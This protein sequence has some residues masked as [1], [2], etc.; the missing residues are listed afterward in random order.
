M[1]IM[2]K[3]LIVD[4]EKI[5]RNGIRFLLKQMGIKAEIFEAANGVKA[6]ELLE[7]QEVDLLLTD[8]KMPFMDGMTL[9]QNAAQ[10]YKDIK[11]IIFSGYGEF[12]YVKQAM[13]YSVNNYILKPVDP[14]E[15]ESTMKKVLKEIEEE[16]A[17]RELHEEGIQFVREHILLSLINGAELKDVLGKLEKIVSVDFLEQYHCM[18]LLEFDREFFGRRDEEFEKRILEDSEVMYLNLN[19]Q[20]CILL[21]EHNIESDWRDF[22]R[23]LQ[24]EIEQIY[25]ET[26][27]I[28]VSGYS[29]DALDLAASYETLETLMENKFYEPESRVFL[30]DDEKHEEEDADIEDDILV[31]QIRQDIKVKDMVG[32]REHVGLLCDKYR[33]RKALSQ[34]YVKFV[35]SNL[36]KDMY[37]V[38][39]GKDRAGFNMVVD[40]LYRANDFSEV[41][42]IL[43]DG[44]RKLEE[45][46]AVNPQ[47]MHREIETVKEYIYANYD[48]ELS[49]DMLAEQVYLA[50]SYLSHIFKK[51][52][53]QNLSKFIKSLR[54]EKAKEMLMESHLKIINISYAVGYP[55]VSYFCQSFREYFG[56][57]PQKFRNQGEGNEIH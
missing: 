20:Q 43:Q 25:H 39:P 38:L 49:V 33:G 40:R 45:V 32:L 52:T 57:S 56:V 5:E 17:E 30:A 2:I 19:Q 12:E 54:M 1:R 37:D 13:M 9:I 41:M 27:Y 16:K 31:R 21:F 28:A 7:Q 4:D 44:I 22:A 48:K 51:E 10:K 26:C 42:D 3:I 15:F 11:F 55:N 36:M 24:M 23:K 29:E 53:G 14:K 46:F 6:L 18:M 8:I 50:P 34:M 47:M 35:F